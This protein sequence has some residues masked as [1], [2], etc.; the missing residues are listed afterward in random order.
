M[1]PLITFVKI[2]KSYLTLNFQVEAEIFIDVLKLYMYHK[3]YH[4]PCLDRSWENVLH[5]LE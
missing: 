3:P 5:P 1:I 2:E 4:F